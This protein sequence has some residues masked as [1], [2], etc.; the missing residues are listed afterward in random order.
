MIGTISTERR[1]LMPKFNRGCVVPTLVLTETSGTSGAYLGRAF[2]VHKRVDVGATT[3][4][5]D[6][7]NA[8]ADPQYDF[9]GFHDFTSVSVV[10]SYVDDA[11]R[12]GALTAIAPVLPPRAGVLAS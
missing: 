1:E 3:E 12:S 10:I 4:I 2:P 8:Y 5:V 6:P 7:P 9:G 11:G